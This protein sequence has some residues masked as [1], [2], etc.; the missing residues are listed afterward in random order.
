MV[1]INTTASD[2]WSFGDGR[3]NEPAGLCAAVSINGGPSVSIGA[4]TGLIRSA[5]TESR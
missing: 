5:F 4:I 3:V 2:E 1:V